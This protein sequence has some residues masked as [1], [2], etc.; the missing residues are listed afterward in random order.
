MGLAQHERVPFASGAASA[1]NAVN[2]I[3]GMDRHVEVE[4]VAHIR[5]VE[6]TSRHIRRDQKADIAAA[7]AV[8]GARAHR[9][10]KVAMDGSGVKPVFFH[11]FRQNIYVNLAVAEDNTVG[12]LVTFRGD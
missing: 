5:N 6:A 2:V 12:D 4:N 9:L 1:A 11:G 7:K 10:I 8:E 3:L